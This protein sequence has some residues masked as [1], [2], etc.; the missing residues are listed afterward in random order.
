MGSAS[1]QALARA[2]GM[3]DRTHG[4]S[5]ASGAALFTAANAIGESAQL[6]AALGDAG[7]SPEAKRALA[8]RLFAERIDEHGAAVLDEA[9]SQRWSNEREFTLGLQELAIRAIAH[10]TGEHERIGRE[11]Q[12]FLDVVTS[13]S[14][15]ELTLAAK[16]G[17]PA[18]KVQLVDRLFGGRLGEASMQIIRN[19]VAA[20]AG[21]RLRRIITQAIETVADQ[22][23]RVLA[24]VTVARP[25]DPGQLTR[26]QL[27]LARR[28][29]QPVAISQLID[30]E[31]VG[32]MRIELGDEVIDD[33]VAGRLGD[34]RR[35]FA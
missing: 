24:V 6:R 9:V 7:A 29:G 34:L 32:G 13:S 12:D 4:A 22:A 18:A 28:F 1:K 25:I 20:P 33:T 14:E 31:V 17:D 26:L 3:I 5:L 10:F 16:L 11:L 15:L 35:Q 30:P 2:K 27:L 19:L 23:N 8:R 21:R